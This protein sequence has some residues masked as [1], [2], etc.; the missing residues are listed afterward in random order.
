VVVESLS[1]QHLSKFAFGARA[2]LDL[3]TLVLEPD[4]DLV[5]IESKLA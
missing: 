5:F 4:L 1:N 3:G 2:L